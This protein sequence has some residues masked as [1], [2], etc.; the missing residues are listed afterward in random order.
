MK[1]AIPLQQGW[2]IQL[3]TTSS[4]RRW[5]ETYL[6]EPWCPEILNGV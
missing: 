5:L 4:T 6:I 2:F 3:F 1:H